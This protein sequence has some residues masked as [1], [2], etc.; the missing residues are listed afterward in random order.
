MALDKFKAAPLPNPPSQWDPQYMRQVIRVLEN[1]FSQLDSRAYNNS[2]Q[3]SADRFIGGSFSGTS[4]DATD[5]STAALDFI[6]GTGGY[7]GVNG[8][9]TVA[10]ISDGHRNGGQIS[11]H[12]MAQEI[13]ADYL[14]GDGRYVSTPYNQ[15]SSASS[16]TAPDVATANALTLTTDEFPDGISIASSSHIVLS[17]PGIYNITYSLQFKNTLNNSE[18]IDVWLRYNGTDLAN[19]NTRF[20]I[21]PRKSAGDPS[22]LVAVTPIMVDVTAAND[23]VEI[24]W[25]VSD[26]S[27]TLEALPA[28]TASPGVTPAIPATPSAIIGVTFISAQFPPVTRVAPLPVFGF[29]QIGAITVVTR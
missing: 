16:Q 5:V 3:Y 11:D 4:V 22:Y 24:M 26:V 9:Q 14:H 21:P 2:E 20:A 29:G 6:A 10:L 12:I 18:S 13:Y 15:L 27:V 28:V 8:L 7:L 19:S 23:Y 17:E 25:R 1:Y